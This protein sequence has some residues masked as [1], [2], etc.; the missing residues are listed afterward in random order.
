MLYQ[1]DDPY[2]D[3]EW[4]TADYMLTPFKKAREKILGRV[5]GSESP[6]FQEPQFSEEDQVVRERFSK[7][8]LESIIQ[9]T[10]H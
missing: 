6:Y 1:E 3:Y 7:Q 2:L 4:L 10:C 8:L 5:K 9:R